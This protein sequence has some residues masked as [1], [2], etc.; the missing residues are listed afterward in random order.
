M[1][2]GQKNINIQDYIRVILKHQWTILT[3]FAVIVVSVTIFSF[4]A[5][6]IY[7]ATT[8]IIIE[9]E[10]PKVVSIQEVMSVDSSGLDYYQTQYKI[11]EG[12]GV[13]NEVIKRLNL[14]KS[15]EFNPRQGVLGEIWNWIFSPVDYIGSLLKTG[16]PINV[17]AGSI[18]GIA[19]PYSPLVGVVASRITVSPI[20]NSRL[21]DISF[22]SKER[23]LAAQ[24]ANTVARSY[25]DLMLQSKVKATQDA[26]AWLNQ[27][28]EQEK[29]RVEKAETALLSFKETKGI[30]TDFSSNVES[31]TAQ[32]LAILNNQVVEA[33]SK[34]VEAETRFRQAKSMEGSPDSMGSVAEVLNNLLIQDI[35]RQEVEIYKKLSELS[36]RYGA[37]HP[38]IIA[39]NNEMKTLNERKAGEIQ[40]IITALQNEYRVALSREQSLRGAMSQQ[41]G[42]SMSMNQEAANYSALKREADMSRDIFDVLL[43]RFKETSLTEDIRTGNIRIVD[44]AEIPKSPVKPKKA[45][46]ILLAIVVGLSMGIGLAFFLEYIDN[47]IKLPEEIT[48]LLK[49]P[50]LGPVPAIASEQD[51]EGREQEREPQDDLI[52][53]RAP[54]STASESYRGIRTSLLFSSADQAPQVIMVCSSGPREGKTITSANIAV[55]MAQTGSKVL[56]MDCD[57][58]RPK[59]NKLFGADRDMGMSNI[60]V[61]NA[62]LEEAVI[63]TQV[64]NIDIIASGPIPPNPSE[65][66]GSRHMQA[67]IEEAR[68]SYDRIIID[69]PPITAVTDAVILS[70][71]VDGV[72]VVIRAGVTHREII[73]NGV[74]QLKSV[75]A[76][77]LGA[78]LNGVQMGRDS[79]YYYQYYYYYYGEDGE[80]RKNV[81]SKRSLKS[82]LYYGQDAVKPGMAPKRSLLSRFFPGKKKSQSAK[83]DPKAPRKA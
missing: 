76:H 42:E 73:K 61:G 11:L 13:A 20:R 78:V 44:P 63:H 46:N 48:S 47:T 27:Q 72:V 80:K 38:Q 2:I 3:V 64:P 56:I 54:K 35:K 39:L 59:L 57:M 41:K 14:E 65:L 83:A 77:I 82:R 51:A 29:I 21:V 18:L 9:K 49:I 75:N 55:T 43:K 24:V 28:I 50:Y 69:S 31:I 23:V 70:N 12:R 7:R 45:Q 22:E 40:R 30:T 37:N 71:F 16:Q 17:P 53:L 33:T 66:L 81:H 60:L 79:Y 5:T 74:A 68:K 26:M 58:R 67:L 1:E 52:S 10:N 62:T 15:E 32:K 19:E 4:T 36:K 6:P 34:R 25:I 8:R